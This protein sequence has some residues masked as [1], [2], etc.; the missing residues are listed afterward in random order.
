M[1]LRM[2]YLH[3]KQNEI[4]QHPARFKVVSCGRRFGK[5]LLAV[6]MIFACAAEGGAAWWV[7]PTSREA[8]IGWKQLRQMAKAVPGA[9]VREADKEIVFQNGGW[10]AVLSA[11]SATLRGEGLDLVVIDEAAFLSN[12]RRVWEY[13]LRA[14]LSDRKGKALFISSP[15]GRTYFYELYRLGQDPEHGEW[16]S[17]TATSYENPY[18]D[19]EEIDAA[20]DLLPEWAFRQEYLAEFVTFAGKVYKDFTPE[21]EHVFHGEPDYSLYREYWGGID[22]GFTNPTCVAIG[23]VDRDDRLDIIDGLYQPNLTTPLLVEQVKAYQER[24]GI[25]R[26]FCDPADPDAIAQLNAARIDAVPAPRNRISLERSSIKDG[27]I[28]VES[29][30]R[31]KRLRINAS[32]TPPDFIDSM[33]QYRYPDEREGRE[34]KEQPLKVYDHFPDALR[35]MVMGLAMYG[36]AP[37][38]RVAT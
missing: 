24:Y 12:L 28:K 18:L 9:T 10:L 15:D 29:L 36:R 21:S 2:P 19:A 32:T 7:G 14:A 37:R 31:Q 20:K 22:F 34:I 17:W 3:P 13:D 25:R 11:E 35:Y 38:V 23:G 26:W 8:K 4:R 6:A 1:K 30:L 27:I 16:M 5:T 33:D